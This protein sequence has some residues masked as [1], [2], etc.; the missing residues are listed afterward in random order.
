MLTELDN[1][2]IQT[3]NPQIGDFEAAEMKIDKVK[4]KNK[5]NGILLAIYAT[6]LGLIIGSGYVIIRNR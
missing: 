3:V 4:F 1:L 2:Y 6:L 5:I